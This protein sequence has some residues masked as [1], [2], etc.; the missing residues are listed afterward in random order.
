[1]VKGI[2]KNGSRPKNSDQWSGLSKS[3]DS[4]VD[5]ASS[6]LQSAGSLCRQLRS[7]K[8]SQMFKD[9]VAQT[10]QA[11]GRYFPA[12]HHTIPDLTRA[13]LQLADMPQSTFRPL[14]PLRP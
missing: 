11:D 5:N 14:E 6:R 9:W 12:I 2:D 7:D 4:E 1:M 3:V 10:V 13:V 8:V